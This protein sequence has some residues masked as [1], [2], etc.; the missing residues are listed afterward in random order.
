M[1]KRAGYIL[2]STLLAGE[3]SQ[4]AAESRIRG[5]PGVINRKTKWPRRLV[6]A[7]FANPALRTPPTQS[8]LEFFL[9][10]DTLVCKAIVRSAA[11]IDL[12]ADRFNLLELPAPTMTPASPK[13]E[14]WK[15]PAIATSGQLADRLGL[16]ISDLD[17]LAD[18]R[19]SER[20][21]RN[22]RSTHYRY[23]WISKRNGGQR[24]LEAPKPKLKAA[25]RWI[26]KEILAHV[27]PH[28]AANAFI[29]GRSPIT[30][31]QQHS[32]RE[33]VL[34]IDLREFFP[35]VSGSR[36]GGIFRSVGFPATVVRL[37]T[38]L[39]TNAAWY[40]IQTSRT[41][42]SENVDQ[43]TLRHYFCAH[44]PQGAPTSPALANLCAYS[45]DCRLTGL[46]GKFGGHYTR[47]AD[48]LV[49]SG[50]ETFAKTLSR[51]RILALAIIHNEGFEIRRRKTQVMKSHQQQKITGLVVNKSPAISRRD[52][53][54]LR[55][56]L[57]N[58]VRL[59]P[60]SQN[61]DL[62][63]DF[64]AHLQGKIAYV[65]SVSPGKAERLQRTMDAIDWSGEYG[66]SGA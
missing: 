61:R 2:A 17:F 47:Y 10:H 65:R 28:D 3:W 46:A 40:G 62:H 57:T 50:D 54:R 66:D 15:I 55:A 13:F 5:L 9:R 43:S 12:W 26:T 52:F 31:A 42:L 44:L 6:A 48:D 21:R 14:P 59:G 64:R 45:L 25:Q 35:S 8:R 36:V 37:L 19:N 32:G 23:S 60:A 16:S 49:F 30:A 58:C 41:G 56:I 51:F 1:D 24:L 34:R 39:T 53:D 63:P 38:G 18:V 7:L 4:A 29:V 11:S 22:Q 33:V 20:F 27:P